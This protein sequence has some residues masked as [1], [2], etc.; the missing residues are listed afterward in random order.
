MSTSTVI[1]SNLWTRQVLLNNVWMRNSKIF[2]NTLWFCLWKSTTTSRFRINLT[3]NF[4]VACRCATFWTTCYII[5][6]SNDSRRQ[7]S[8]L[9]HPSMKNVTINKQKNMVSCQF[10]CR[11]PCTTQLALRLFWVVK[12]QKYQVL[13]ETYWV[14]LV[15]T[16]NNIL[17]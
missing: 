3:S 13:L 16:P 7:T 4:P 15:Q 17:S 10:W 1:Q 11:N 14:F 2:V 5:N 9:L 6:L 8:R 12:M